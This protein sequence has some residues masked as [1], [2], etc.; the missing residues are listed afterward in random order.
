MT[1]S[2][3]YLGGPRV[4]QGARGRQRRGAARGEGQTRSNL[5]G[6][7]EAR[8]RQRRGAYRGEGH[9]RSNL[10]EQTEARG[11]QRRG[12]YKGK[13]Q[14]EARADKKLLEV[15]DRIEAEARGGQQAT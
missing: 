11:R 4:R 10:K 1:K 8:S 9:T 12:A 3:D 15:V 2:Y 14:T 7:T 6:Q 5:K 13:G